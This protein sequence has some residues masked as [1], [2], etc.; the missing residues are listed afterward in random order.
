MRVCLGGCQTMTEEH[1]ATRGCTVVVA[2]AGC[3]A[4]IVLFW[5][6]RNRNP[7]PP[8]R[9]SGP[10]PAGWPGDDKALE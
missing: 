8:R 6:G 1:Q 2:G 10:P 4:F 5:K 9:P 7:Q 3:F